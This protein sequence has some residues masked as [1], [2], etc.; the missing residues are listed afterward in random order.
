MRSMSFDICSAERLPDIL[1]PLVDVQN[2]MG[3]LFLAVVSTIVAT[4]MNNFALSKLQVSVMSAFGGLSTM[5]TIAIG[6][7]WGGEKLYFFHYI[8]ILLIVTRMIGVSYIAIKRE[9]KNGV[10][11]YGK[12][13]LSDIK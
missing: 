12:V 2:L 9:K 4:G 8:G 6:V 11:D 1:P 13:E 10:S 5:V 7:L 3:F